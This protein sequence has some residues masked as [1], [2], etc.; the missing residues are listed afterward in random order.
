LRGSGEG[1]SPAR[2]AIVQ[3]AACL[4]GGD[5]VRLLVRVEDG[6]AL[7]VRD[8][9]AT[10]A[11][12]GRLARQHIELRVGEDARLLFAEQPLI[13]ARG[14][15]LERRL[16]LT[17]QE[18]AQV[19]HRDTIVLGRHGEEPGAAQV[20]VRVQRGARPLLD[21]TLQTA[22]LAVLRSAAVLGDVR[23]VA[24]LGRYGVPGPA[25]DGAFVLGPD[26]TLVRRLAGQAR[27]LQPLD[28][29]QRVWTDELF[30]APAPGAGT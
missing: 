9:S 20:R 22:D 8:I 12:P 14:A 3:T 16:M 10:L 6:A 15:Q 7:E 11:H 27:E 19:V 1:L 26:D 29:L 17:L 4:V 25:P 30:R 21:E 23:A 2:V 28:A 18:G 5:D 13:I 24:A